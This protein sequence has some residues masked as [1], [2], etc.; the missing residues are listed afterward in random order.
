MGE[1]ENRVDAEAR[2][3]RDEEGSSVD[4]RARAQFAT[5]RFSR[6][7]SLSRS[8]WMASLDYSGTFNFQVLSKYWLPDRLCQ[9]LNICKYANPQ[10]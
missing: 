9:S 8:Q 1:G 3:R 10:I 4:A 5:V 6:F 7:L 2:W